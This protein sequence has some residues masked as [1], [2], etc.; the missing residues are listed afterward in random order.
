[1]L[2]LYPAALLNPFSSCNRSFSMSNPLPQGT[3]W[4]GNCPKCRFIFL[5]LAPF[6][7]KEELI[8]IFQKDLLNDESQ[9]QGYL[10]LLGL[11]GHKP[12]E[13]VGEIRECRLA[14]A[15]IANKLEW[16]HD[17]IIKEIKKVKNEELSNWLAEGNEILQISDIDAMPPSYRE[18]LN[19]F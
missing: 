6:I 4:C 15:L 8:S 9:K 10:E 12:F 14:F 17:L 19:A 16:Q 3:H 2:I 11:T 7:A 1:M 5:A 13:C 18:I